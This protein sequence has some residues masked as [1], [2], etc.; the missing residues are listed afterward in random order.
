MTS[1]ATRLAIKA[2]L[3]LACADERGGCRLCQR[4]LHAALAAFEAE[5]AQAFDLVAHLQ[6]QRE[7]SSRTFGH[8]PRTKGVVGHIRKELEEIERAPTDL[9]EWIDVVILGLDGA[10]RSGATPAEI[11]AALQAKQA[12]NEG[13]QWPKPTSD[14]V[15]IEHV[16]DTPAAAAPSVERCPRCGS[17]NRSLHDPLCA[18]L[19]GP[20]PWHDSQPATAGTRC[21][22][23]GHRKHLGLC[24]EA[25]PGTRQIN[26]CACTAPQ[27][28]EP[29]ARGCDDF[30]EILSEAI[31]RVR[32]NSSYD[33]S[34]HVARL[35]ELYD[36]AASGA[37]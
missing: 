22:T 29:G 33:V 18:S 28:T 35:F 14:D 21:E 36:A 25:V 31:G 26:Y 3:L 30:S 20:H 10:W 5:G 17:N 9:T 15:P 4:Q 2:G 12:T 34:K 11:V 1:A 32:G 7:W 6:R 37:R 19:P 27:P 8:G 24:N 23:C 13:R 16:R